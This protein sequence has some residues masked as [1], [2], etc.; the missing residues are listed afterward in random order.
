MF[1]QQCSAK[2]AVGLGFMVFSEYTCPTEYDRV[3]A[4][5][6]EV[7]AEKL[8]VNGTCRKEIR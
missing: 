5:K 1:I 8:E 2:M 4:E 6:L 7:I 3:I